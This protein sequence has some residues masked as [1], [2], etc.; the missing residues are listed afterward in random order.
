MSRFECSSVLLI[1][2]FFVVGF[3]DRDAVG[4]GPAPGQA[5]RHRALSIPVKQAA[6]ATF[7]P[8]GCPVVVVGQD[9]WYLKTGKVVRRLQGKYDARGR[10]ALSGNGRHFAAVREQGSR[11]AG[12]D[13][14]PPLIVWS[15]AT[16]KQVLEI[17]RSA[18]VDFLMFARYKYLMVGAEGTDAIEIWDV[19]AGK[20][21]KKMMLPQEQPIDSPAGGQNSAEEDKPSDGFPSGIPQR[22]FL[23]YDKGV[24]DFSPDARYFACVVSDELGV[25][26]A[27]SGKRVV[28]MRP[29]SPRRASSGTF[30]HLKKGVEPTLP[31][32][33]SLKFSP[34]GKHLAASAHRRVLCWDMQGELV[35][36]GPVRLVGTRGKP[37]FEWLPGQLGWIVDRNVYGRN[38]K[39]VLMALHTSA[40][41]DRPL[42]V[43]DADN[44]LGVFG[45]PESHLRNLPI[46]W[47]SFRASLDRMK[48]GVPA[49]LAPG[50][51]VS[52]RVQITNP[53]GDVNKT[54]GIIVDAL[55]RRLEHDGMR[56]ADGQPSVLQVRLA[57]KAGRQLRIRI[58]RPDGRVAE[59]VCVEA[60][61]SVVVELLGAGESEPAWSKAFHAKN[62]RTFDEAVIN[63]QTVRMSMLRNVANVLESLEMPYYLPKSKEY[64]ALPVFVE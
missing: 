62:P 28:V 63:D 8:T 1:A 37:V 36:D 47:D 19:E 29:P 42:H 51:S 35:F 61:G 11:D 13:K 7:G 59:I 21:V 53:R 9:V 50:Q 33:R 34:D 4:Q 39:Q 25:Y 56:V 27:A 23:L 60:E 32:I 2:I 10:R 38:S 52:L 5:V 55:T 40:S 31:L 49:L 18:K 43:R 14:G 48:A 24:L 3:P 17:P 57:E 54:K 41:H 6:S 58:Q 15:C 30:G 20:L 46:P 16:G 22:S 45:E 12:P 26:E 44:L 64:R